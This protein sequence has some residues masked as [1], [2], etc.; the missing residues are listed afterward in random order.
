MSVVVSCLAFIVIAMLLAAI[1][2]GIVVMVKRG[3]QTATL[4]KSVTPDGYVAVNV[5]TNLYTAATP[6]TSVS[7]SL[8]ANQHD[9]DNTY[10][11][12]YD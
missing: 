11:K 4:T 8:L 3:Q 12:Q 2:V 9:P 5:D 10:R 7:A 6:T 1:V